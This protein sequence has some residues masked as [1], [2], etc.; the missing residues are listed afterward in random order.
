[1]WK[2][3]FSSALYASLGTILIFSSLHVSFAQI[4]QSTNYQIQS[5]SINFSG[6]LSSSTNYVLQSTAG[7]VGTGLSQSDSYA[8]RAGYQQMHEVYIAISSVA[9][10][11]LSPS[12]PGVTGGFSS[13][14]TTFT[15]T[16]D[17]P[18]GYALT[19]ESS[20]TPAMSKG[21]DVIND[22]TPS[23]ANPDFNFNTDATDTHFGFSPDGVD[24]VQRFKDNGALCN[25]GTLTTSGTCWDGLSTTPE[26]IASDTNSNHPSGAT[27]TLLF[28]VGVGSS[29]VQPEGVYA[30][31]T[32]ITA[33]P[34]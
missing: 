17:S 26:T 28:R 33:L 4:R 29:V 14:S 13:A 10:I 3:L 25:G 30:A 20:A 1:M 32:T 8:L 22:Y 2:N 15:V 27:T 23:G 7:E 6:G 24:V 9:D 11:T 12:I 19:I 16:T 34:L 31:T 18:S 21:V 5:D